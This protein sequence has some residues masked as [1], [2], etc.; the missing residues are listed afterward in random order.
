MKQAMRETGREVY[1]V[2]ACISICMY[3]CDVCMYVYTGNRVS[4]SKNLERAVD[5]MLKAL[6]GDGLENVHGEE[7]GTSVSQSLCSPPPPF[8]SPS[9]CL[10]G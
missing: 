4:G 2:V 10:T 1:L 6:E 3:M 9:A 8:P 7:A 5:Y